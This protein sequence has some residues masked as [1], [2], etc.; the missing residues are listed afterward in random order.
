MYLAK[1]HIQGRVE[2]YTEGR[3]QGPHQ[4]FNARHLPRDA[5][6]KTASHVLRK[7]ET[8][9][10][11]FASKTAGSASTPLN[12]VV[13]KCVPFTTFFHTST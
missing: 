12:I 9:T 1:Q 4:L 5:T 11:R 3:W 6:T 8:R 13:F 2:G 10:A 7:Q